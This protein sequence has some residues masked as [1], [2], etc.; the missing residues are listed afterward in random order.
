MIEEEET[1]LEEVPTPAISDPVVGTDPGG[2]V[3]DPGK[4][5]KLKAGGEFDFN[6]DEPFVPYVVA[7][8]RDGKLRYKKP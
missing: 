7:T 5:P 4:K 1:A 3:N 2:D 8:P 6:P